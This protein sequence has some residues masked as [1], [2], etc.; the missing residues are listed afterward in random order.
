MAVVVVG[1]PTRALAPAVAPHP[2]LF[3]D[4]GE[5]PIAVVA[6]EAVRGVGAAREAFQP[7]AVDEEDVQ[8]AVVV[9][10]KKGDAAAGR[11]E[12]EILCLLA[13]PNPSFGEGRARPEIGI[14]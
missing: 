6:I 11:F 12:D 1:A 14:L 13:P 5:G 4:V 9:V 3:R 10:V 8:P 2:C 7:R